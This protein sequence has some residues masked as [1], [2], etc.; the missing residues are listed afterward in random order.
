MK[1]EKA[2]AWLAFAAVSIIWGTTYLAIRVA[3]ETLP[4]ML[5]PAARFILGGSL[6]FALALLWPSA[7]VASLEAEGSRG[8]ARISITSSGRAARPSKNV[9]S[10]A[11]TPPRAVVDAPQ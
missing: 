4:N 1:H 6:L 7:E 2:L 5:F 11:T 10:S 3:V 8:G 9:Q